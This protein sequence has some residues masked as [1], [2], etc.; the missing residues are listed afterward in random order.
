MISFHNVSKRFGS[1]V[2]LEEVNFQIQG[3]DFVVLTGASGAGKSTIVNLLIGSDKPNQGTVE[4]DGVIVNEMNEE[5]L[6]LYRRK[7]GVVHQD[8]K[9]LPKKTAY[10]NVA[11]ALEV[12]EASDEDIHR[13]VPEVLDKVGLLHYQDKFPDQLSGGEKQRL[14][15][16][17]AL[18]HGPKFIIADEPTGNLD[19]NNV[20]G[21]LELLKKLHDEGVTILIT[22]HDPL[23]RDMMNARKLNLEAGKVTES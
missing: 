15:I 11:F 8:Y 5:T 16:A 19:E 23:V 17:R 7:I 13:I 2:V 18:A 1:H 21:I 20:R 6:Q 22:T 10:E 9:L 3:N 14:A 4:V 12:C